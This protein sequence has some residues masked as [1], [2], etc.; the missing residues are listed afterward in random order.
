[1]NLAALIAAQTPGPSTSPTL[2]GI[3]VDPDDAQ[4]LKEPDTFCYWV[5]ER[6]GDKW[7][8]A[9]A[10]WFLARP[11]QILLILVLAFFARIVI[12]RAITRL[13]NRAAEG[14]VPGVLARRK[15]VSFFEGASPL[16]SERRRQRTQTMASVLRSVSTGAIFAVASVMVL[17]ELGIDIA[18]I[19]ASA[20]ILG[21]ALG[22]GSQTLV[23]DFLSGI[24]MIL[25]DQYGV[26]DVVDVGEAS[27]SVESV[28]LRVTRLRDLNGT[29]WYVRNGE[30]LRVGNKSQGWAR[31]VIDVPVAYEEDVA[32]VRDLLK[33][34]AS[35]LW[36]DE[37]YHELIL[38]EPEVWG[39]E[40]L[41]ADAVV[42]RVVVKT[43]PLKQ[44]DVARE[45][46]ERIK[47][48]F[49]EHDVELPFPQRSV[50]LRPDGS[51]DQADPANRGDTPTR[52][53]GPPRLPN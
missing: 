41:S 23:K 46:R 14:T 3:N 13:A 21:V 45:M 15:S 5:Y 53:G 12:H 38:E 25:E 26:G 27:G 47:A 1:M 33:E 36:E 6:T 24:F 30:I 28:G 22:F 29:V 51:D 40:S 16:L 4:C 11:L 37:N 34:A 52:P 19:I 17:A 48:A 35:K 50:W 2:P 32:R 39:V 42:V 43:Q 8:G 9:F 18:P 49:D 44:W 7:L 31:A 10:D 20:G